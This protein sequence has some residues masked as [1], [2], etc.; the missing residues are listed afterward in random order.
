MAS[1]SR[2]CEWKN[3]DAAATPLV[4][5]V[6]YLFVYH[7]MNVRSTLLNS[8]FWTLHPVYCQNVHI[9]DMNIL[10]PD[11]KAP[12]GGAPNGDGIDVR[13]CSWQRG[14]A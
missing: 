10:A 4:Q 5:S 6:P 12:G 7:S 1:R 13:V 3:N 9:H 14:S 2:A 11:Y 8:G